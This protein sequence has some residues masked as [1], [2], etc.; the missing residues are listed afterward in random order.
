MSMYEKLESL[1]SA[2]QAQSLL[3][4][5]N[6]LKTRI[7]TIKRLSIYQ[8]RIKYIKNAHK[9][10]VSGTS[11]LLG[12]GSRF[13]PRGRAAPACSHGRGQQSIGEAVAGLELFCEILGTVLEHGAA[14]RD[15]LAGQSTGGQPQIEVFNRPRG[16]M[17]KAPP[18]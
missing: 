11:R 12:V 15:R 9:Y 14:V 8:K 18:S 16:L 7:N 10:R 4:H 5:I 17:D 13:G 2:E 3:Q 1:L 6:I